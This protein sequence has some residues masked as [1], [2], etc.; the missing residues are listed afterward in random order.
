MATGLQIDTRI[1]GTIK[2]SPAQI[3]VM[4]ML[5]VPGCELQAR[6]DEEL[7]KNPALEEGLDKTQD[8]DEPDA[9]AIDD[10]YDNP[11]QNSDFDYDDYV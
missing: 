10:P 1:T 3:Q 5:E 11:L 8:N 9:E 7:Q 4:K 6:I 2:L